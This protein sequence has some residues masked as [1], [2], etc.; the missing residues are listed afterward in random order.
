MI[1]AARYTPKKTQWHGSVHIVA[2]L[3]GAAGSHAG[4]D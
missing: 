4:L 2:W 3:P 1:T